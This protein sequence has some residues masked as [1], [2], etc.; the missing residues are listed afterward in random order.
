[1]PFFPVE[2][3]GRENLPP[4]SQP[5]VFVANHQARKW[6][7]RCD[8][9]PI[10]WLRMPVGTWPYKETRMTGGRAAL[11]APCMGENSRRPFLQSFMDIYSLF[12]LWRFFKF[13]SKTSNFLIP[14]IG[15]SMYLTGHVGLKRTDKRSQIQAR[16]PAPVE[17]TSVWRMS[18]S[19]RARGWNSGCPELQVQR[20]TCVGDSAPA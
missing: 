18:P 10:R 12:H 3:R 2:I 6:L 1:M 20:P 9:D 19:T 14:I 13:I 8:S 15:W 5:V 16:P 7:S 17:S 11:G 4:R